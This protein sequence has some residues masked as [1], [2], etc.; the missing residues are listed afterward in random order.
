VA[1]GGF[2]GSAAAGAGLSATEAG[3]RSPGNVTG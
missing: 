1:A 2:A 3:M